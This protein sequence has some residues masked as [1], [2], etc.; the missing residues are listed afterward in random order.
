MKKSP[1]LEQ[2]W[3][4]YYKICIYFC[5]SSISE[6]QIWVKSHELLCYKC[7]WKFQYPPKLL[8]TVWNMHASSNYISNYI[9]LVYKWW[10]FLVLV[11]I[12]LTLYVP[13]V[14]PPPLLTADYLFKLWYLFNFWQDWWLWP[15]DYMLRIVRLKSWP[16]STNL[17]YAM[18]NIRKWVCNCYKKHKHMDSPQMWPYNLVSYMTLAFHFHACRF[19][20][21]LET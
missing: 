9:T 3:C 4:L 17:P 20:I 19:T 8:D 2:F 11:L 15:V 18:L 13:P 12:S 5:V 21:S 10:L 1:Q 7:T 6:C 16:L 14:H